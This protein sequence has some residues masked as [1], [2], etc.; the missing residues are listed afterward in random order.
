MRITNNQDIDPVLAVWLLHDEYD[1][2]D[3]PNYIS[4]TRLLRPLKHI[5]MA[6]RVPNELKEMD[7]ADLIARSSGNAYHAAIERA[8]KTGRHRALKLLGYPEDAINRILVNPEPSELTPDTIP[9]YIEQRIKREIDG[10]IV[11]GKFDM[12][13]EGLLRDNKS[14]SAYTWVYGGRD[15]EHKLQGSLYRWLD[16]KKITEDFI[17]INYIFT[18]WQVAQAKQNPKYPQ[19]KLETKDIKLMSLK[20][21][22]EWIRWKLSMVTKYAK[23]PEEQIPECSDE[24]LWRSAPKFKYYS[25]PNKTD[26]K[27]TKNFDDIVAARTFMTNEKG[28]KGIVKTVPG[29]VKRCGYCD[30]YPICHQKDR[31]FNG[32]D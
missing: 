1:Y 19:K 6:P 11:G 17:R 8:W 2:D 15:E 3:T 22:E 32:T 13:L 24:E 18:D 23:A 30:I 10:F 31:Y 21:T 4:A 28:G 25:D 5:V 26:G 27:S 20:E 12:V 16:P 29:E 14:T 7:V 9:V